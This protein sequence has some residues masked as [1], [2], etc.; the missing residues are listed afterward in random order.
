M[1]ENFKGRDMYFNLEGGSLRYGEI[2]KLKHKVYRFLSEHGMLFSEINIRQQVSLFIEE[3]ENGLA[4]RASSLKMLP[5]FLESVDRPNMD[6]TKPVIVLD[7][8]GTN[9]RTALIGFDSKCTPVIKEISKTVMPGVDREVSKEEFFE[10]IADTMANIINSG[11]SIGFV[12]SY[13]IEILP[14]RDGKLLNFTKEIKAAE[15]EGVEIGKTLMHYLKKKNPGAGKKISLLNDT[16]AALLAGVLA[17]PDRFYESYAGL[18]LGTGM[19]ASYFEKN[20]NI[21]KLNY[22]KS[23]SG[24]NLSQIINIEAGNFSKG[25]IGAIDRK[26]DSLTLNPGASTYE[27]MFSG[28]YLG[29]LALMVLKEA[30]KSGMFSGEFSGKMGNLGQLFSRDIDSFLNFPP[31]T[32]SIFG[33]HISS[34]K[35]SD[36]V[37]LYFIFDALIER[38][39]VLVTTVIA[40]IILK[41]GA[42]KNP[43][44]PLC[45]TAEGSS[46]YRMKNFGLRVHCHL[47]NFLKGK[48]QHFLEIRGVDNAAL[49]GGAAAALI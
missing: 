23:H 18:V 4:G 33:N 42:G 35:A 41:T 38:A 16:V 25:P 27:K 2:P 7:A 12:F 48:K 11:S 24:N 40:S 9:L 26:F 8:G 44:F 1:K 47:G 30:V 20:R 36:N 43:C 6:F 22:G 37:L 15:V 14:D 46:F 3:M 29:G 31:E 5:A 45:L 34:F 21:S 49:L 28:A 13:P 19:N 17:Y 39:A 10:A 32:G